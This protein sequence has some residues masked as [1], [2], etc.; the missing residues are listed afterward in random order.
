MKPFEGFVFLCG[1]PQDLTR[2]TP[3]LSVRH[4]LYNA[5]TSGRY[6]DLAA[7]LKLAEDIQDWYRGG[8]YSDLVT[9][10]EHLASLSSV[11]VLVVESAGSIAELGAFSVTNAIADRLMALVSEAH[12]EEDSFIRHGP[13]SRLESRTGR[14]VGVHPWH[15]LGLGGRLVENFE[16][17]RDDVPAIVDEVRTF[18]TPATGEKVFKASD[19]SHPM[20]L[21][22]EL[23]ELFG[24]LSENEIRDYLEIVRCGIVR[25]TVSQYLFLLEKCGLLQQKARGNGRYYYAPGWRSHI[26]FGF[27]DGAG[28]DRFRVATDVFNYYKV[29]NKTRFDV[30]SRLRGAA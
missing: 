17:I 26:V 8:T 10:E 25:E 14:R 6:A 20:L 13:I 21:I 22:C 15:E 3:E 16:L 27:S 1:G 30:V 2:P 29:A 18:L 9:F 23:C 5:M 12:F 19:P 28:V 24:A 4:I 11:I 7:R